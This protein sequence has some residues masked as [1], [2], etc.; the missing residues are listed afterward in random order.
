MKQVTWLFTDEQLNENDII[1]ME[2]SLGV[3][4]PEDYKNCIKKYNGGY[5]EPNIYYFNDGGDF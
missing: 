4:F 2:N 5:P 3:K 1:T